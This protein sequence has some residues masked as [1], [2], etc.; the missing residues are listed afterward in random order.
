MKR[1]QT[2][3]IGTVI[4]VVALFFVLRQADFA[5]IAAAYQTA[6]Y[7]YV[8]YAVGVLFLI[9]WIRGWRWSALNE[10]RLSIADGFWLFNIGFL[11]NNVMPFRLGELA[12]IGLASHRP[13]MH[14]ASALSS[15]VIERLFDVI[16]VLL[17]FIVVL[18]G[19]DL[20]PWLNASGIGL[21]IGGLVGLAI[22]RLA[23]IY[24]DQTIE[25]T[26]RVLSRVPR[27]DQDVVRRTL[28]PFVDGLAGVANWRVFLA[29]LILTILAW[30]GSVI[31]GYLLMLAFWDQ[32]PPIFGV[33][34]IAAAG[35][36][37]SVPSAPSGVGPF[38]A[39]VIGALVAVGLDDNLSRSYAFA[40]HA[41]NFSVTTLLGMIGLV[42]EGVTFNQVAEE[43]R[44]LKIQDAA[45]APEVAT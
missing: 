37:V 41:M 27:I 21:A 13:K 31:S 16:G 40:L 22:M 18:I 24:P 20:P 10:G 2:I 36:G 26:A 12:R 3:L 4:S 29:G 8:A 45:S 5:E 25:L 9:T 35:L 17:L 1:W 30:G 23:S 33:L 14:V 15:T 11:F 7:E 39:A 32:V 42:R 44:S 28:S 6:R 43:A 19:L 38:H 34:A